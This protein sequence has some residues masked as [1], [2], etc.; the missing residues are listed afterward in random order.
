MFAYP[1]QRP[2]LLLTT[3]S[4]SGFFYGDIDMPLFSK[5]FTMIPDELYSDTRLSDSEILLYGKI[6]SLTTRLGYC[7]LTNDNLAGI[8]SVSTRTISR[9]IA[10]L[11]ACGYIEVEYAGEYREERRIYPQILPE[12]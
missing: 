5:Q 11:K 12:Y 1:P 6:A 7:P 8:R 9:Y 2:G 4:S 3:L 10:N